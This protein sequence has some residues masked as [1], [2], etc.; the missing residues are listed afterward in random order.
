MIAPAGLRAVITAA[1]LATVGAADAPAQGSAPIRQRTVYEDLQMFSQVL[2]QIRVNHPDSMDTHALFMAAIEGM[3]AAADPHSYVIPYNR[4]SPEREKELRAGRL[5]PVPLTFRFVGG[6]PVVVSVAPGSKAAALDVV[7]GDELIAIDD[8]PVAARSADELDLVLAGPRNTTVSLRFERRRADGSIAR[9]DR[10]VPREV[11]E[12]ATAVP[13]AILLPEGTAVDEQAA[14]RGRPGYVRVTTFV[15]DRVADDLR[16]ALDRLEKAGMQGLVLDLRENGGGRLDQAA[17]IAGAFLPRGSIVYTTAGRKK[18]TYDT[19]RVQRSFWSSERRYPIVV[20]V[21]A[22]T[23]SASELVAGALQDHDRALIVG[24]ST[25]GKALMMQGFPLA[26]GSVVML[27]IGTVHTPC[28]RSIQRE[29]RGITTREYYRASAD[30][31]DVLSRPSCTTAGGRTVYGGGGIHPD[32]VLPHGVTPPW[33]SRILEQDLPLRWVPGFLDAGGAPFPDVEAM[34]ADPSLRDEAIADFRAFA[35]QQ[36]VEVPETPEAS[37]ALTRVLLLR[38]ARVRW[39]EAGAYS[40][41]AAL[42]PA[43][44]QAAGYLDQAAALEGPPDGP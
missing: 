11:V 18:E 10:A 19:I 5:V 37:R 15:H 12:P 38:I 32:V 22:G 39:G 4:L 30:E 14:P 23:A 40:L 3:V 20:M 36:G 13:V 8:A 27:V 1:A 25:F 6:S 41:I 2:N 31:R 24:Q 43:V 17:R 21:N 42:D 35:A 16:D 34:G 26:D 29:Y 44:R 9:L 28:G 7:P 33:L